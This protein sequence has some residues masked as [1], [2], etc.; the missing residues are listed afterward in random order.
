MKNAILIDGMWCEPY[1][2][3]TL[4]RN[5]E[6]VACRRLN[7]QGMVNR[8]N[9]GSIQCGNNI[10]QVK[11]WAVMVGVLLA[12]ILC[13]SL[14]LVAETYGQPL[15]RQGNTLTGQQRST[16]TQPSTIVHS[17]G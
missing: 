3:L 9:R 17:R 13:A 12:S 16:S 1:A 5:G 14:Y 4:D 7:E 15:S 10:V 2:V 11:S 6:V 8:V